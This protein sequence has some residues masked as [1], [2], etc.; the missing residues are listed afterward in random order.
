MIRCWPVAFNPE[1]I[2]RFHDAVAEPGALD[3]FWTD[4]TG[5]QANFQ[6]IDVP[7]H[8]GFGVFVTEL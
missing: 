2:Q 3:S 1:W 7:M 4:F 8:L 6:D 5:T